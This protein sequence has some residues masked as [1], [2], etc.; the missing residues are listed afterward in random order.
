MPLGIGI[1]TGGTF[2]DSAIVD[3]DS[4]RVLSKAKALT[5]KQDLEIGI[6]ESLDSLDGSLFPE[7]KLVALSTTLATNS[8]V[9]GK[10][11]RVGLIV[12]VPDPLTFKPASKI[13]ADDI[14]F[15]AGAHDKLGEVS[16]PLDTSAVVRTI[17]RMVENVDAFAVSCYFSIYNAE[18]ELEIKRL[19]REACDLPVVC[20]HELSGQVGMVERATTAALNAR[21]LP[22]VRELLDSVKAIMAK[23]NI[24][25]PLMVVKGDG[26]LI[27]EEAA[28]ERPV[29]T[30]LS[31][32]AASVIGA[33]RL[34][35]LE[36][37]IVV[38]MGGTT[39]DIAVVSGGA[40]KT[41]EEGAIVGGWQ[42]RVRA[43]DMW[44]A[45][46][47]GDSKIV[48]GPMGEIAIGPRRAVP[49]C[50]AASMYPPLIESLR[51]LLGRRGK[52]LQE[53]RIDFFTLVRRPV[54][55]VSD[56]ERRLMDALDGRVLHRDEVADEVSPFIQIDRYV[57]LGYIAEVSL[58]PTDL[59]HAEGELALWNADAS[60]EAI[61]F[62]AGRARVDRD[63]LIRRIFR[64]ITDALKLNIS[65][66]ALLDAENADRRL[67]MESQ[68][69]LDYLLRLNGSGSLSAGM[70][71][72]PPLV[73]VG[74][75][76]GA[77]MPLVAEELGAK[78]VIPEHSEVANAVG[79][80]TG[81]VVERAEVFV[82][83]DKPDGFIVVSPEEHRRFQDLA[84]ALAFAEEYVRELAALRVSEFGGVDIGT[85]VETV[86]K[87]AALPAGWGDAVLMEYRLV[88]TAVGRP[89][90][91]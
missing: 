49:L 52:R 30:V 55:A 32:P 54:F 85:S 31:G 72:R 50:S 48:V 15:V 9:E 35:G 10:G 38:D 69:F 77:Y 65:T 64:G 68:N 66:Q 89:E 26:T 83:P 20:G 47:G 63:E 45:G 58:T 46:L 12:A 24:I 37:A 71:I 76:V 27:R 22:V 61:R 16:V 78:L 91:S 41:T 74:A 62:L 87:S 5:T 3:L 90:Y 67:L 1:D 21:L 17:E 80:I 86:E 73:A 60:E 33:C 19:I 6:G 14:A 40:T 7:V 51:A 4:G 44:T 25:A 75:P 82:R 18:H 57:E 42:T 59:L 43:V 29:E 13:P 79:A 70:T 2:T 28:R 11:S 39:T 56:V 8:V 53:T 23:K 84:G 88:G 36:E 81:R 34:T